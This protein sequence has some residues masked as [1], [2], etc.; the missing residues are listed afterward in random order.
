[1]FFLFFFLIVELYF[2]ISPAIAQIF[3]PV[4]DLVNPIGTTSKETKAEMEIHPISVDTKI[5]QYNLELY[6]PFFAIYSSIRFAIFL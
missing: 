6:K 4:A 2:L 5:V 3:N 1:M